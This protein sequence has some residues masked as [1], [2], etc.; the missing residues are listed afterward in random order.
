MEIDKAHVADLT[1]QLLEALGQDIERE[2]LRDTPRRVADF[3]AEFLAEQTGKIATSFTEETTGEMVV[4]SGM[5]VW[6]LCE[7]HLLPFWCDISIAYKPHGQIL[8]LSKFARIAQRFA[9]QLQ[10]QERLIR[11]ISNMVIELISSNDV[12]TVGKGVHTCM[13]MRGVST[14]ATM[15]VIDPHGVF[16]LENAYTDLLLHMKADRL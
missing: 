4:V 12:L 16:K 3:W 14:P 5:R 9:H 8:G 13:I 1:R 6:S 11:S 15:T 7:H 10:V 2:G